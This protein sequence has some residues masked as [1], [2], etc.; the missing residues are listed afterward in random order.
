MNEQHTAAQSP[1]LLFGV[2]E[3]TENREAKNNLKK[4][5]LALTGVKTAFI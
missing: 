3:E 1:E 4:W 5:L 2:F